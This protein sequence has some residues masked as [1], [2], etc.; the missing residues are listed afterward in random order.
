MPSAGRE[1]AEQG[2]E[3]GLVVEVEALGIE[4]RREGLVICASSSAWVPL[5]KR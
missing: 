2:A 4:L 1:P 3:R 5:V